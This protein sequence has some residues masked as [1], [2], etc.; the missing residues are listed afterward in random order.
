MEAPDLSPPVLPTTVPT[1][2]RLL[3]GANLQ[4][5]SRLGFPGIGPDDAGRATA[6]PLT[7]YRPARLGGDSSAS[8]F[9]RHSRSV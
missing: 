8:S 6:E 7:A 5:G 2:A 1:M 9:A 3:E 4:S